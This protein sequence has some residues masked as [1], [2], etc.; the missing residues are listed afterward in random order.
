MTIA[1]LPQEVTDAVSGKLTFE[2]SKNR[3]IG[4][5]QNNLPRLLI[6]ADGDQFVMKVSQPNINVLTATDAQ[7]I[8]NSGNNIFKIVSKLTIPISISPPNTGAY[9][10]QVSVPH[11]LGYTPTY[12]AYADDLSIGGGARTL[13]PSQEYSPGAYAT[14]IPS[15]VK[16]IWV[17]S[18]DVLIQLSVKGITGTWSYNCTV[19]LKRETAN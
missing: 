8:F 14:L 3:I 15:I 16:Q 2:Q 10:T 1:A 5:D 7:L 9:Q 11:G 13:I 12:E 17:D 19:Y 18:T 6:L 4:R